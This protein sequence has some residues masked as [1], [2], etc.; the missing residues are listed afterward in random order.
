MEENNIKYKKKTKAVDILDK[1]GFWVFHYISDAATASN[2]DVIFTA[3]QPCEILQV[4]A[5]WR[6]AGTVDSTLQIEKLTSGQALDAGSTILTAAFDT[7]ATANTPII[8]TSRDLVFTNA[9]KFDVGDRIA[10][11]DSGTLTTLAGLQV[12]IY[13]QRTGKGHYQ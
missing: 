13:L 8:K 3:L 6:V 4:S 10:L 7:T 11:K 5:T 9:R 1:D 12:T 2:Y